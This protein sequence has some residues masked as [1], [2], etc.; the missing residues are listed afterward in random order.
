[1]YLFGSPPTP[2]TPHSWGC[3]ATYPQHVG[4]LGMRENLWIAVDEPGLSGRG[5]RGRPGRPGRGRGGAGGGGAGGGGA[6]GRG[7]A[8]AGAGARADEQRGGEAPQEGRRDHA[9]EV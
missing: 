7:G 3:R 4:R 1:M 6:A 8:G 9:G 2:L 5:R